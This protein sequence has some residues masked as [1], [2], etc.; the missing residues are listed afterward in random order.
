MSQISDR[1]A[2]RV[3]TVTL[4][5]GAGE[6]GGAAGA[7]R[8]GCTRSGSQPLQAPGGA[9]AAR[10]WRRFGPGCGMGRPPMGLPAEAGGAA[11]HSLEDLCCRGGGSLLR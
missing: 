1:L 2:S 9:A 8:W 6:G 7:E 4:R 10:V 5:G 3:S 11:A